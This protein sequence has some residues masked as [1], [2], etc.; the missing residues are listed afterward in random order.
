MGLDLPILLFCGL[1][2]VFVLGIGATSGSPHRQDRGRHLSNR[3]GERGRSGRLYPPGQIGR[4]GRLNRRLDGSRGRA[5]RR[6]NAEL[7]EPPSGQIIR[8]R[9]N[10]TYP[11][12]GLVEVY[13]GGR[14]G[15]ICDDRWTMLNSDVVCKQ[16]GYSRG[17]LL[18]EYG[19][20]YGTESWSSED[21]LMDDVNC[22]GSEKKI[23]QCS[24]SADHDCQ[25][26]EAVSISCQV[27]LDCPPNWIAGVD[28]CYSFEISNIRARRIAA[29]FCDRM[30]SHL[31]IIETAQENHFLSDILMSTTQ[32][33]MTRWL[34]GGKRH[35]N[36][37]TWLWKDVTS[38]DADNFQSRRQ[39]SMFTNWFPGW[40]PDG[41][42]AEPTNGNN[43]LCVGL[44]NSYLFPN[45]TYGNVNYYFG[46]TYPA[47]VEP[48][49]I[50]FARRPSIERQRQWMTSLTVTL[51]T[52]LIMKGMLLK[53]HVDQLASSGQ[54]RR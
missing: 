53:Q 42:S 28:S 6:R 16:L 36:G 32:G 15:I 22:Q 50:L 2:L 41:D 46:R 7:V 14:W 30:D 25:I 12:Y 51:E 19:T 44:G 33:D 35:R 54:I 21:I 34:L 47:V 9:G 1:I 40:L 10:G 38:Y 24:Y 23:Q 4:R 17:A 52:V 37:D 27:N 31:A 29:Q 43:E 8:L 49:Y 26:S 11:N 18:A 3:R 39:S 48:D 20:P 13:R 45:N 5:D